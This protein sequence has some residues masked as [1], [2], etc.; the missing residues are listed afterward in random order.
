MP[1]SHRLLPE[2]L[3]NLVR[4][5]GAVDRQS[6]LVNAAGHVVHILQPTGREVAHPSGAYGGPHP[7]LYP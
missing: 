1:G 5:D 4:A 3:L 2:L 7:T 6:V